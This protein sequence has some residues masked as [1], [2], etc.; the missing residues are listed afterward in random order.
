MTNDLPTI[1]AAAE[2]AP[3]A[4]VVAIAADPAPRVRVCPE[5]SGDFS[6]PVKGPGQHKRF[7]SDKCRTDW[8][9]REKAEGA[10]LI[11]VARIWRKTRGAGEIGK[12]A[13]EEMTSIL[14]TINARHS[15][16]GRHPL[17]ATSPVAPYVKDVLAERFIDRDRSYLKRKA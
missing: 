4:A 7:C 14:D 9:A 3:V 17:N 15:A 5:C 10:V 13:F 6:P 11:T 12:R 1:A 8:R 16:E 2:I